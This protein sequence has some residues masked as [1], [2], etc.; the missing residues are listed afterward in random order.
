MSVL[1]QYLGMDENS[2][3]QTELK[4]II[5]REEEEKNRTSGGE[6]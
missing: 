6:N 1:E 3:G 5:E 4:K 2:I